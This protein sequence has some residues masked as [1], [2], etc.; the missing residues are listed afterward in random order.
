MHKKNVKKLALRCKATYL[1]CA[2]NDLVITL[3]RTNGFN[4]FLK[5]LKMNKRTL[6]SG[7]F[8]HCNSFQPLADNNLMITS[9]MYQLANFLLLINK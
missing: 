7:S 2:K 9:R 1:C 4:L 8:S 5:P 3:E 6:L